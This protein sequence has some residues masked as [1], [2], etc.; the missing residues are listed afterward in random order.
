MKTAG[1]SE[2]TVVMGIT[3][4]SGA[5]YAQRLLRGL[6]ES[7]VRVHLMISVHGRQLLEEELGI[8][9]EGMGLLAGET[10]ERVTVH[11]VTDLSRP[12]ASGSFRTDGMVICPCSSNTLGAVASGRGDNLIYRAAQVT[13]KERRRL[14]LVY[15]E[16]PMSAIDLENALTLTRAGAVFCPACPAYYHHPR[17]IGGLVDFVAGRVLDLLD[18]EHTLNV[19][20]PQL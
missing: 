9:T 6:V 16:M 5:L 11:D 4:A 10:C 18:V 17:D 15:R 2:R 1:E 7:G 14:I 20:W 12:P 19:R 3:G 8:G 13:L